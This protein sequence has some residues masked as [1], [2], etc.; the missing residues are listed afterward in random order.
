ML[1]AVL[2]VSVAGTPL[3]NVFTVAILAVVLQWLS[4]LLRTLPVPVP[5][6]PFLPPRCSVAERNPYI[7]LQVALC[8]ALSLAAARHAQHAPTAAPR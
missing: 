8:G 2:L 7:H 1:F 3:W 6:A 4:P 5:L